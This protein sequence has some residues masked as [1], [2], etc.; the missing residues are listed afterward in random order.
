MKDVTGL[1]T[2][3][4]TFLI[5]GVGGIKSNSGYCIGNQCYA[6]FQDPGNFT[7]AQNQCRETGGR[8]MTV[9]SSVSQDVIFILLVSLPGKYWIGLHLP[10]GCPDSAAGLKGF[11]WKPCSPPKVTIFETV[12]YS[13]PYGFNGA[14]FLSLPQGTTATIIPSE[15]KY[16]CF[17]AQWLK[18][19]WTCEIQEGG[20]EY[21]CAASPQHAPSCFCPP[22]QAVSPANNVTCEVS[23]DDPCVLLR[24]HH[25]CY[26]REDDSYACMC[27]HG[28]ELAGDGRTCVDFNDCRDERLC[29]GQNFKCVNTDGS[30]QCVCEDGYRLIDGR[31]V[32]VD[33]CA[34]APCEHMCDNTPGSYKCACF[35]GYIVIPETPDKCQRHCGVEECNAECDPN[36]PHQCYCPEGYILDVREDSSMVCVDIDECSMMDCDQK[37]KNTYGSYVCSCLAGYTLVDQWKCVKTE[38]EETGT[39]GVA[40]T[41]YISITPS[42]RYPEPTR[43]PSQVTA[44]GL[45]SIILCIVVIILVLVFVVNHILKKRGKI[46]TALKAQGGEDHDLQQVKTEEQEKQP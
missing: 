45:V 46:E 16:I 36:N 29:P 21:K 32:D 19:P 34:S 22:G 37:C 25:A 39:S 10:S 30:F 28:F 9:R 27:D 14:D 2:I 35:D 44:G 13:T 15:T 8:L 3:A 43:R 7:A 42:V 11:Q 24:C 20:C 33:E 4:L 26:Q 6:V 41:P 1:F 17:S 5:G 18:A 12:T 40:P 31:C 38:E 23:R